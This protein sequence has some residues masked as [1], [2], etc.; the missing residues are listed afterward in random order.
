MSPRDHVMT[1]QETI[2][3]IGPDF[4]ARAADN[5]AN[6]AFARENF[7]TLKAHRLFSA[8]VPT[9][10]GGGG[11]DHSEMCAAIRRLGSYCGA[12]ALTFSMHSHLI[13]AAVFNHLNGKPGKALLEKVAANELMLISTGAGDWLTSSGEMTKVDGG[14]KL[15]ARKNFASGSV[16]GDV[17]ITS[18]VYDHP[19]DGPQV[20]HFP[21]PMSADGVS[22]L[23]NWQT[24]GMRATGSNSILLEDVFVPHEAVV[25]SRPQGEYHPVWNPI[26]VVALPLIMSAYQGIADALSA[27]ARKFAAGKAHDGQLPYLMG[28]ME[29]AL[30]TAE[31]AWQSLV[32]NANDWDFQPTIET[33]N[34]ALKLKTIAANAV[35][36]VAAKAL[37]STG[38][39]GYH[40]GLGME[41]LLRESLAG[42][43]HPLQ[44]K[45]QHHF[46]G[47]LAMGLAP[48]EA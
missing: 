14:Y 40:R 44:E 46:T 28:E 33:A 18:S 42:Q 12:T 11:A 37:E 8:M 36:E 25:L 19:D 3:A 17:I 32:A 35:M 2:E 9:D 21:V 26:L 23:D 4:A 15:T 29:N 43:F 48:V 24:M 38:G 1:I 31:I 47:R 16:M 7:E 5:D 22:V 34:Q 10:L 20:L 41:R 39:A 27:R 13:A 45:R 6:D 30:T